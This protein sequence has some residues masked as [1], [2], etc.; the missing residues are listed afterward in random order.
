[1]TAIIEN[2]PVTLAI[3]FVIIMISVIWKDERNNDYD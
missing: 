3:L 2:L 1:M